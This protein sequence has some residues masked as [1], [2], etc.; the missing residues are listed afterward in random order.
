MSD[1][2]SKQNPVKLGVFGFGCVGQGLQQ[3]L[4]ET[5]GINAEIMK[6]CIKDGGKKRS[7][8]PSLFTTDGDDILN[9][10]EIDIVVELIDDS[11]AAF[12]IVKSALQK[13]KAVVSANKKMIAENLPELYDLQQ[14]YKTPFLYEGSCCAS[15][16]IIRNLE[17]YYDNDLLSSVEGIFNGSTNYILSSVFNENI[18]FEKAL[19]QAQKLGFAESDPT[20]DLEGYDP[21]YKTSIVILHTFGLFIPPTEI[22][23]YGIQNLNAFDIEIAKKKGSTI[24]LVSKCAKRDGKVYAYCLPK[25][26]N[27]N[28]PLSKVDEEYNGIIVESCFAE[29]QF[30]A[31]KGAGAQP[32]GSAVISDI[33]AIT[34]HYKYEYKKIRQ[35]NGYEHGDNINLKV[36]MRYRPYASIDLTRFSTISEKYSSSKGSY[37]IG[38]IN[39]KELWYYKQIDEADLN[40]VLLEEV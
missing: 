32:T 30:F 27:G 2:Q 25:F 40:M 10:P 34:Y 39:L 12:K 36:Y 17:E 8:P 5:R 26:V 13:R 22:F 35:K 1:T 24:K 3:V 7:L 21:V 11:E 16:P 14:K 38:T 6:I 18:T 9:D 20:L 19:N 33:S 15:I 29:N 31:G 28:T 37:V 23:H 4:S